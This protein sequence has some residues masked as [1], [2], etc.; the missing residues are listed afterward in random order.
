[1]QKWGDRLANKKNQEKGER[2]NLALTPQITK[3]LNEYC[4]AIANQKGKM[5]HGIK[6]NI[7]RRAIQEWLDRHGKDLTIEF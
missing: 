2:L 5:P 7:A 6:A 3:R 1:M 4:L